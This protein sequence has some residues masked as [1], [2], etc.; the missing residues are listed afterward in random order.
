MFELQAT[1]AKQLDICLRMLYADGIDFR[2]RVVENS[3]QKIEYRIALH[4]DDEE[5]YRKLLE[6]YRILVS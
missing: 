5:I 6:R 1:N 4:T 2:V 3:K